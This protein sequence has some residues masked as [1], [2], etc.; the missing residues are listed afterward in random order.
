[1]AKMT[2]QVVQQFV[3]LPTRG[4][5]ATQPNS[6]PAVANLLLS[7]NQTLVSPNMAVPLEIGQL[8]KKMRVLDSIHEDGAKLVEMFPDDVSALRA[9]NPGLRIV[10]VVYY[11]PALA[12][13]KEVAA[14]VAQTR[15][16]KS[17]S[18]QVVSAA[19]QL[20]IAG[21]TVVAFTDFAN[22]AGA[23]GVTNAKGQVSLALGAGTKKIERLYLY[24]VSGFWNGLQQ[25][26]TLKT[27]AKFQLRKIDLAYTDELKFLY[28]NV[29]LADGTGVTVGVVD[30]GI[31]NH[32][33]LTIA[34][35]QNTVQGEDPKDYGDN[36]EGHGTHVGGIIAGRG[37]P[38]N[39]VRGMAP[40]VK[41]RSY[42]VFGKGAK[43][44]TNYAIAKG[45]DAAMQDQC[46]LIN[47]SLGGGAPDEATKAA[48]AD[49][50]AAGSLVIVAAGNDGR[51]PVSFP[52]SD[53]LSMAVSAL[54]RKGTYPANTVEGGDEMAPFASSDPKD[55][56]AAFSNVGPEIAFTGPG[57]G[58]ISTFPNGY[59][60]MDGTSMA[61]PAVT[62]VAARLLAAEKQI[63]AMQ[64]NSARS[65]AMAKF[66]MQAAKSLGLGV[67]FEGRGLLS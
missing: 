45:V 33:D 66:L 30:T 60:V 15:A 23:Q 49:A 48:I 10:P 57:V 61:C 8:T 16:A 4:L 12:P 28:P 3:V 53:P 14:A 18:I 41:L 22:K 6:S 35:G 40:S 62:G 13:R 50:R 37:T 21:V 26:I 56:I 24:A 52:A 55:F 1:M 19:D 39:G 64:R 51:Q 36:G 65:D 34:G 38:P 59:A 63:L 17:I 2:K 7:L 31:A 43:G 46:D 54:G 25:N 58:I 42:R 9:A 47:M 11:Y 32:P 29:A 5:R 67:T 44:A 27:G 20:P